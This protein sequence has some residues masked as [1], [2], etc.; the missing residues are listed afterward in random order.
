MIRRGYCSI[1]VASHGGTWPIRFVS[2]NYTYSWKNFANKFCLVI[3]VSSPTVILLWKFF[4]HINQTRPKQGATKLLRRGGCFAFSQRHHWRGS[5]FSAC[6]GVCRDQ[7]VGFW[8][9]N[10]VHGLSVNM[11]RRCRVGG[12]GQGSLTVGSNHLESWAQRY[13]SWLLACPKRKSLTQRK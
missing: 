5:I 11:G 4:H 1:T 13:H 8:K 10:P 3:H 9:S 2:K 12:K 6:G 7:V